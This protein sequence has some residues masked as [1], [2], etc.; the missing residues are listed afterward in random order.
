[1]MS[2]RLEGE[3]VPLSN[4]PAS[5]ELYRLIVES[6]SELVAVLDDRGEVL[7]ASP[8]HEH[9]LG[10][11]PDELIGEDIASLVHPD[12]LQRA[13][14]A[15]AA[16]RPGTRTLLRDLRLRHRSGHWLTVEGALTAAAY[17][18]D[19]QLL[20]FTARD[21][22]EAT[23]RDRAEREFVANA[24]HELLTPLTAM[25][26]A[27]DVLQTGAKEIPAERDA[28]ID[29]LERGADRLARLAH[30]L[31]VLAR[32]Q[33]TEEPL[34]VRPVALKPLVTE[35]AQSVR[36]GE[37]IEVRVDCPMQLAV[38]AERDLLE[39]AI[40]NLAENAAAHTSRGS[41]MLMARP[42]A[43]DSVEIEVRDTGPGMPPEVRERAFERFYRTGTRGGDGFGLGLAIVREAMRVLNGRI[44]IATEP[45][46]G[47]RRAP[48]P[49]CRAG[50]G[51][52]SGRV[53]V[54]EDEPTIRRAVGYALRRD[55][56]DVEEI[57]DGAEAIAVQQ[58]EFD[59]VILDLG[60]PSVSGIEV[61]RQMRAT[62]PVPII[63]LTVLGTESDKVLGLELGRRRLRD[64]AIRD[65][66]ADEPRARDDP[67]PG[68]RGREGRP[69]AHD[70][71]D[72][73]RPRAPRGHGR[74]APGLPD[75]LAVQ[76]ARA[77]RRSA[78]RRRAPA[79][80]H[81]APLGERLHRRRPRLR[82][83]HLESALEGR[84]R[85]VAAAAHPDDPRRGVQARARVDGCQAPCRF[86]GGM[87]G[88]G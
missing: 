3:R 74:R 81:A 32:V 88:T 10:Y 5:S 1:M 9:K 83:A 54:V 22:T 75:R 12:D 40:A 18:G 56:F 77:A 43:S 29:D 20:L 45:G 44:E 6:I 76:A 78:R 58:D 2:P 71:R 15:L 25:S 80:D 28:F 50:G 17:D 73:D 49:A 31:L 64:Q 57:G 59:V 19:S 63:V 33:A 48:H 86:A 35:V 60:L 11:P 34:R 39:R 52:M 41:I 79:G 27:I 13:V 14:A 70:R 7:Y 51:R 46:V 87:P 68:A 53:L 67:P 85:P 55:G 72:P 8:G 26:A 21:V 84:A 47:H 30:A 62:G 69:G 16:A 61:L 37:G 38:L 23:R 24:A 65:G 36:P 66:R 82:C 42:C 4:L